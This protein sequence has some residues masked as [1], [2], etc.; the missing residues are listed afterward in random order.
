MTEEIPGFIQE[1][2]GLWSPC[3]NEIERRKDWYKRER[4]EERDEI[5]RRKN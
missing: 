4:R 5:E 1:F 3:H 2:P